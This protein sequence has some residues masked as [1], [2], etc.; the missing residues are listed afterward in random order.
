MPRR[1]RVLSH[2]VT[3]ALA[4]LL[5][6][7]CASVDSRNDNR[8]T[9]FDEPFNDRATVGSNNCLLIAQRLDSANQCINGES[10]TFISAAA[11]KHSLGRRDQHAPRR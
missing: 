2:A 8:V 4:A 11:D 7:G 5:A 6:G 3:A 9:V 1:H 10:V